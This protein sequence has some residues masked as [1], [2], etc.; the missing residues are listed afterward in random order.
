M[1]GLHIQ[2][3]PERRFDPERSSLTEAERR[4]LDECPSC[5]M[6]FGA[7][8]PLDVA[9]LP[10]PSVVSTILG[11]LKPVKP[12]PSVS[13]LALIFGTVLIVVLALFTY[14]AGAKGFFALS[15]T[16]RMLLFSIIGVGAMLFSFSVAQQMIPGSLRR[17][18]LWPIAIALCL[19]FFGM[20]GLLF[21][22]VTNWAPPRTIHACLWIGLGAAALTAAIGSLIVRRGAWADRFSTIVSIGA[23]SGVSAL[24]VLTVHCPILKASHV[25]LWHGGAVLLVLLAAW[26]VGRRYE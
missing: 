13:R 7:A 11:D 22:D 4:H 15:P 10:R 12:L 8:A 21:W 17:V 16:A 23:L 2:F 1:N 3:D 24:L 5:Q 14:M 19:A 25:F 9:S 6:L 18:P 20:V 26:I